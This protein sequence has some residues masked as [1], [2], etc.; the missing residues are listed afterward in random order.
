[1]H[2]Y[3]RTNNKKVAPTPTDESNEAFDLA[4]RLVNET[5]RHLFITGRAGTGKTTFLR[6]IRNSCDKQM[7]VVA[8][9]GVAAINAGGVTIHSF[10][11]LPFTPFVPGSHSDN[12]TSIDKHQL[13]SRLRLSGERKK[14]I[15]E[16]ELLV[17]DEISM[18]R[19]DLL[20]AIDTVM[21]SVRKEYRKP[22][23]GVQ[24]VF[25]GDLFQ[26]PPVVPGAT[27]SIL[28]AY[29]DS[30]YFFSSRVVKASPPLFIEFTRIYRQR[31]SVFVDLLNQV[32]HNGLTKEAIELLGSRYKPG[33]QPAV[34]DGYIVLTTHHHKA[35]LIN[36]TALNKIEGDVHAFDAT[37]KGEFSD[38]SF[39]TDRQLKLKVGAQVMFMRNDTEGAKRFFNGKIG[40]V[41]SVQQDKVYVQCDD[42]PEEIEVKRET[43]ENIRYSVGATGH[44]VEE[45]V[46]GSFIQFP[47]RL[48]WAI[49]IHKSQGLTFQ[50]VVIDAG[51][52]FAPGQVYVALSRCTSLEGLILQTKINATSLRSDER[53]LSFMSRQATADLEELIIESK[54]DYELSVFS[55][56][57]DF[58][59]V[60]RMIGHL[61]DLLIGNNIP[62]HEAGR[63]WISSL[64]KDAAHGAH[65]SER[66]LQQLQQLNRENSAKLVI[67]QRILA[68]VDFFIGLADGMKR[69]VGSA[70]VLTYS[71]EHA[72][73][74]ILLLNEVYIRLCESLYRLEFAREGRDPVEFRNYKS[75]F[76]AAELVL[77]NSIV[78]V[79]DSADGKVHAELY[80][81]L[82]AFR[83]QLCREKKCLPYHIATNKM[84]ED[85][86]TFLP[87]T[88]EELAVLA[89]FGK[90]RVAM[91]GPGFLDLVVEY[92]R[93]HSISSRIMYH[94]GRPTQKRFTSIE[95]LNRG[96]RLV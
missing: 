22:F 46:L 27:W 36:A 47:L 80:Q 60:Q 35:D 25:I 17:I 74:L 61:D 42:D 48:A 96:R 34:G 33:F 30:P 67:R 16:L 56:I 83:D 55:Q 24:V 84:L 13:L 57:F 68:G 59:P 58:S 5:S 92:C 93:L 75:L 18:V 81:Q 14:V 49:T 94:P 69:S 64:C 91:Y 88:D 77:S 43:W 65:V 39:P 78:E 52:A 15:Q 71:N 72:Q 38:K 11:Q 4:V 10:F 89:G 20:D 23:G 37:I 63:T 40:R 19:A 76:Q 12:T 1:M 79:S 6:F 54:K 21:R 44:Q 73:R 9:T 51:N 70:P 7:A 8:P 53:I 41:S 85:I 66:F 26:L 82:K 50:K 86:S 2:L 28:S 45:E 3:S 29:Y 31:D 95:N 90:K 32:R 87:Q 62:I